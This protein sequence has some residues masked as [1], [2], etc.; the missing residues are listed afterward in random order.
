VIL[1][2]DIAIAAIVIGGGIAIW[3]A[4]RRKTITATATIDKTY[5]IS[6][7]ITAGRTPVGVTAVTAVLS[8]SSDKEPGDEAQAIDP[9]FQ[10]TFESGLKLDSTSTEKVGLTL[11]NPNKFPDTPPPRDQIWVRV[12]YAESKKK[13]VRPKI[14]PGDEVST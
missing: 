1:A 9:V 10:T 7:N 2:D 13:L 8:T 5:F 12:D 11:Y 6:V 3:A 14:L 4:S